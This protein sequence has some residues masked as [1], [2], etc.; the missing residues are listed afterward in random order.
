M[1]RYEI[2]VAGHLEIRRAR[3]LGAE[4]CRRLP[5]GRSLLVFALADPSATYGT[6]ARLRDAG[7]ELECPSRGCPPVTMR[8][9][10]ETAMRP[11][12]DLATHPPCVGL[13]PLRELA[14]ER[15]DHARRGWHRAA[16]AET[17]GRG[18][19]SGPADRRLTLPSSPGPGDDRPFTPAT[20]TAAALDRR[21]GT[22]RRRR[23]CNSC[24]TSGGARSGP[25]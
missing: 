22:S 7:L 21:A 20:R 5:D 18:P 14:R 16:G 11:R 13:D 9:E 12:D 8:R 2:R 17:R 3:A 15:I 6:L 19:T 1:N 23:T 10:R 24:V 4:A 25:P